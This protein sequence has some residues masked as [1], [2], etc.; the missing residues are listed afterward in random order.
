MSL[1]FPLDDIMSILSWNRATPRIN[2]F[3]VS[4]LFQIMGSAL[5]A[6]GFVL[7]SAAFSVSGTVVWLA[8]FAVLFMVASPGVDVYLKD[9]LHWVKTAAVTIAIVFCVTALLLLVFVSIVEFKHINFNKSA[10]ELPLLMASFKEVFGYND[11]TAL[12]QQAAVNL[13]EGKNPYT[14]ANIVSATIDFNARKDKLTPLR[15]GQFANIFPYPTPDQLQQ[16]WQDASQDPS[17]IPPELESKFNYPAACFLLPAP[18]IWLGV[19]DFRLIYLIFLIPVLVYVAFI[20]PGKYRFFFIVALMASVQ[21]WNS[22]AGGE[23]GFLYFPFLLLAWVLYRKNI[24][25]SAVFMGLVIATKQITW[26]FLPFYLVVIFRTM[27]WRRFMAA[28]AIIIGIF[29]AANVWFFA[30]DPS[31]WLSSI[32]APVVDKMFP[33]GVGIISLVSGGLV[34]VQ[35]SLVFNIL[36]IAVFALGIVWYYFNC[37]RYPDTALILS[38]LPLFFAWR[39]LWGYFYYI[40]IIILASIFI[41]EYGAKTGNNVE[42]L[43]VSEVTR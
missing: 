33:V 12:S 21:L 23:T 36:E 26:F 25:A 11:S 42:M 20:I 7:A 9:R 14:D 41:N 8:F 38:V 17:R 37:R 30:A 43:P 5:S 32:F 10:G 35:S 4:L 16:L 18:F 1:P 13:L 22:L 28:G 6:V 34:N 27:G 15:V 24:W 29:V 3:F 31:L 39:S 40:D 19:G 2:L